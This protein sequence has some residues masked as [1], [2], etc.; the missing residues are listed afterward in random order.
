[1]RHTKGILYKDR[2]GHIRSS[3]T[4]DR[5]PFEGVSIPMTHGPALTE[6]RANVDRFIK[7]WNNHDWLVHVLE[8]LQ[9]ASIAF[10]DDDGDPESRESRDIYDELC[11]A[12]EAADFVLTTI[13]KP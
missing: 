8:R 5:L 9:K 4:Q 1:M 6:A 12:W 11:K 2:D 10:E 3:D 7:V 13:R